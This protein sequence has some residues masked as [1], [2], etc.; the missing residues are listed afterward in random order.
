MNIEYLSLS[1]VSDP[2]GISFG[3]TISSLPHPICL[4]ILQ[5]PN[6]ASVLLVLLHHGNNL[7]AHRRIPVQVILAQFPHL[8][9]GSE[10]SA[11]LLKTCSALD[12]DIGFALSTANIS[13]AFPLRDS[14]LGSMAMECFRMTHSIGCVME[15]EEV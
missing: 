11:L 5:P 4:L 15:T 3:L 14:L 2:R 7:L 9:A 13:Q 8:T 1:G 12:A 10:C 6:L